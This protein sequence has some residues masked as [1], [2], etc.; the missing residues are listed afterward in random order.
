LERKLSELELTDDE[1]H[2]SIRSV[3]GNSHMSHH[4]TS[5]IRFSIQVAVQSVI[6]Y[7]HITHVSHTMSVSTIPL[8]DVTG[9]H[10]RCHGV[11]SHIPHN[12]C[13]DRTPP[14]ESVIGSLYIHTIP[15]I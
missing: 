12:E 8:T 1:L 11:I 7:R 3:L 4:I 5:G 13:Y 9:S 15:L 6:A 10:N 14:P 2:W